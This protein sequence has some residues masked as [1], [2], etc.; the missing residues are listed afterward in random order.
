[1]FVLR[2]IAGL[3]GYV[4]LFAALLF[5]PAGRLDWWRAWALLG[6]LLIVRSINLIGVLR[7]NRALL[8]ER[9]RLPLQSGQP[10]ADRVLLLS[11]MASFAGL[12]AFV[13]FDR[14]RL[15]L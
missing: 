8:V 13:S 6:L 10:L 7:A 2:R 5:L 14:F 9:A 4:G 3:I 1:M 12:I 11:F 15:H